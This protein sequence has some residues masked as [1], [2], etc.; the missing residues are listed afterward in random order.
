MAQFVQT[1]DTL[2]VVADSETDRMRYRSVSLFPFISTALLLSLISI[3]FTSMIK[4][5]QIDEANAI[6]FLFIIIFF[7]SDSVSELYVRIKHLCGTIQRPL[8]AIAAIMLMASVLSWIYLGWHVVKASFNHHPIWLQTTPDITALMVGMVGVLFVDIFHAYL[9]LRWHMEQSPLWVNL[10]LQTAS[11]YT[12]VFASASVFNFLL[13]D[14]DDIFVENSY[15]YGW[16]IY[17]QV[18][19]LGRLLILSEPTKEQAETVARQL[20]S[21]LGLIEGSENCVVAPSPLRS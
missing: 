6:I 10:K 19:H 3:I 18:H 1:E 17:L 13:K 21:H 2:K 4:P 16:Y 8:H 20:K 9:A 7:I 12:F 15:G 14:I 5:T 11:A